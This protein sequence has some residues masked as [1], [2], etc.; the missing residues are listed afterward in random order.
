M[1]ARMADTRRSVISDGS[2]IRWASA[3]PHVAA[4]LVS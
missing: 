4:D 2:I 1:V 3:K